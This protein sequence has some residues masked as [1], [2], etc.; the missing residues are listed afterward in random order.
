MDR[1]HRASGR[2]FGFVRVSTAEQAKSGLGVEAQRAAIDAAAVRQRLALGDTFVDAAVSGGLPLE[3]R[4]A[5]VAALEALRK[6][7]ALIVAKRDRL[8]RDVLNV[9]M[10]ERL[11]G[12]KGARI[13]S[14]AGEGTDDD[15][16]TSVLMRQIVDS[17]RAIRARGHSITDESVARGQAGARR[18]RRWDSLRLSVGGR[19]AVPCA[20]LA[21]T[22]DADPEAG[23]PALGP[24]AATDGGRV[25]SGLRD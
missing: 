21:G 20:E 7:D 13:V 14:A 9:A 1:R 12:R 24:V 25:E 18:T 15:G 8:G 5:L 10:I 17:F 4:P 19:R 22:G 11:A 16:P 6:G 23:A 2:A 3:R